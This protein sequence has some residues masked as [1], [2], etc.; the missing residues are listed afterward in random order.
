MTP[1][2]PSDATVHDL[3]SIL[4]AAAVDRG[5]IDAARSRISFRAA[6]LAELFGHEQDSEIGKAIYH[7]LHFVDDSTQLHLLLLRFKPKPESD[8]E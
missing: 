1:P 8:P 5:L 2:R 7:H 3:E 6:V 4:D